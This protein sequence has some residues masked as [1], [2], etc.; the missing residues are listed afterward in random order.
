MITRLQQK[1]IEKGI[2]QQELS[3]WTTIPLRTIQNLEQG[4]NKIDSLKIKS[5]LSLCRELDCYPEDILED[6][7][8]RFEFTMM[9][10]CK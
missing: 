2:T 7:S 10:I 5:L 4:H 9:R 6:E 1:R 3:N 8:N